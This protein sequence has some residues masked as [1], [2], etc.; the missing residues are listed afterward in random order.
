MGAVCHHSAHWL[1]VLLGRRGRVGKRGGVGRRGRLGLGWLGVYWWL[2]VCGVS[3][4]SC[5]HC[6]TVIKIMKSI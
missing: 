5:L 4:G 2:G 1:L 3:L 6:V